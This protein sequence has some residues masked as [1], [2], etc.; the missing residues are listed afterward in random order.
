MRH[1]LIA[2][3]IACAAGTRRPPPRVDLRALLAAAAADLGSDA[4]ELRSRAYVRARSDA[5]S[6]VVR[7]S[8]EQGLD[9]VAMGGSITQGRGLSNVSSEHY[10]H[11][12]ARALESRCANASK[13]AVM[14]R[15]T[16]GRDS[17]YGVH[18][19]PRVVE[20][21]LSVSRPALLIIEFATNDFEGSGTPGAVSLATELLVGSALALN[22]RPRAP[23]ALVMLE[24]SRGGRGMHANVTEKGRLDGCAAVID[25]DSI[26]P[27]APR[28]WVGSHPSALGH[29]LMAALLVH[30][31]DCARHWRNGTCVTQGNPDETP[32]RMSCARSASANPH[33]NSALRTPVTVLDAAVGDSRAFA[34]IDA[35][36]VTGWRFVEEG[37]ERWGWIA[38]S[39]NSST[40]RFRVTTAV[41]EVTIGFLRSW[42]EMACGQ[43]DLFV[44]DDRAVPPRPDRGERA[45]F[46]NTRR[47]L[48]AKL[49]SALLDGRHR[50][51]TSVYHEHVF[52]DLLL[53]QQRALIA[54]VSFVSPQ[55][56]DAMQR[57]RAEDGGG[58]AIQ[59]EKAEDG[60]LPGLG[61]QRRL[62]REEGKFKLLLIAAY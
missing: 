14:L 34:P 49:T 52:T 13:L 55:Q 30:L 25:F 35:Q 41:G 44:D 28:W 47:R 60:L 1:A 37:D 38:T 3:L 9:I 40:L 45:A 24:T 54:E 59:R 50:A 42:D 51:R 4:D 29:A 22:A 27:K 26:E 16:R 61:Q 10:A 11:R 62:E 58:D 6:A 5:L 20:D 31:T 17:R 19:L 33:T 15:G 36:A 23:V 57:E 21:D 39:S 43:V 12:F 18:Q 2:L 8:C 32:S 48:G 56:C 46:M 7:A 53:L